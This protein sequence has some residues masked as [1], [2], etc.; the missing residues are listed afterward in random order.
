MKNV[1]TILMCTLCIL[2]GIAQSDLSGDQL[3]IPERTPALETLYQQGRDLEENGTAAEINANRLAIKNAWQAIDPN[4]AALYKPI[5]ANRFPETVENVGINGHYRSTTI[6]ERPETPVSPDDWDADLLLRNGY[7]DGI[8]IDATKN[9]SIYVAAYE[10]LM[11][12]GASYDSIYIYR[13]TNNGHSFNEWKKVGVTSP[14]RKLQIISMDGTGSQ[15]LLAYLITES[16]NFQVW[17][18]NMATGAFDAQVIASDV[19]DFSV[20]R[21][22]PTETNSQRVFAAY[23]KS[24]H[25]TYS[26]RSTAGSYG[27]DWADEAP[28]GIFGDQVEF[29]YGRDG[30]CYTTF[31]GFG[32]RS[33]YANANSN[34][35]DPASWETNEILAT[36]STIETLNPTIRATRKPFGTDEVL[37][38]ASSRPAG[39]SDTFK[40]QG[41]RR[42]NGAL[43]DSMFY[44][45]PGSDGSTVH[46]DSWM[47]RG[48]DNELIQ[49]A[50]VMVRSS[51]D[52]NMAL[53]YDG[54]GFYDAQ[55]VGDSGLNVFNGFASVVSETQDGLPCMAFA[56]TNITGEYGLDL[57]FD[58]RST[59]GIEE[60]SFENFK[61]Y[62]NPVQE[63]L[64]LSANNTIESVSIV[65][66]LGQKV[67][68]TSVNQTTSA[69][70]IASLYPGV[71][72]LKVMIDGRSATYKIIKQ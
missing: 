13:S 63:V 59:L 61:F 6:K 55:F 26:A 23:Q 64:N 54:D 21:N 2:T 12:S 31:I 46:I 25:K 58:R 11:G 8:D 14:M 1:I 43:Y 4:V 38:L 32:S 40:G 33:L 10:D 53:T 9:G 5:V 15:Y 47:Q 20:D 18:W 22:Y 56:G 48:N 37:I 60:N 28:L 30:G 44:T 45:N 29:A 57:Y 39:S 35:N 49:T 7:I 70:D 62:P 17:R 52:W 24:D 51:D 69:I 71:Y 72:L 27:F 3:V 66:M 19:I 42:E 36:G 67:M 16:K 68:E 50:N 34:S 65:S 41:Y